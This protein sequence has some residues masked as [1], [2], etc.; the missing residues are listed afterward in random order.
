MSSH[1]DSFVASGSSPKAA[2]I[3]AIGMMTLNRYI[4]AKKITVPP[5]QHV[6]GSRFR[7]E[8]ARRGAGQE[9][10]AESRGRQETKGV[11][12]KNHHD[13]REFWKATLGVH[14][15]RKGGGR[16]TVSM[17]IEDFKPQGRKK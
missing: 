14:L 7:A 12:M 5:V 3:L 11:E 13:A 8:E 6:G 17:H 1:N 9:A 4:A 15:D 10:D 2:K 16:T